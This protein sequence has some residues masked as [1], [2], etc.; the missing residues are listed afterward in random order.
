LLRSRWGGADCGTAPF[1]S[2][3]PV[4][5]P[6]ARQLAINNRRR[7]RAPSPNCQ[8]VIP[9][10]TDPDGDA[11]TLEW[12]IDPTGPLSLPGQGSVVSL[13]GVPPG[14]YS[15]QITARDDRGG[16]ATST[17]TLRVTSPGAP[18]G[19]GA[20]SGEGS[21]SLRLPSLTLSS[22][23]TVILDAGATGVPPA[24]VKSYSYVWALSQKATGQ[25][26]DNSTASVAR[27]NLTRAD[28]YQLQ[29]QVTGGASGVA[30]TATS[31]VRVLQRADPP[32]PRVAPD[33]SC[34]PFQ[35][36]AASDSK[37]SCPDLRIVDAQTG[38][39]PYTN[40]TFAWRVTNMKTGQVKTGIGK[41]FNAG[42]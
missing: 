20:S 10:I 41:E 11:V 7:H 17:V 25:K 30:S 9:A 37:L 32:L 35:A 21:L 13:R 15:L 8:A 6:F 34:G 12:I 1:V 3:H 36:S 24:A 4:A 33:A 14:E 31:N 39:M 29:L 22:G 19:A 26:V 40:T 2:H 23:A 27:F 5:P 18:A 42:R 16:K 38:L 28:T